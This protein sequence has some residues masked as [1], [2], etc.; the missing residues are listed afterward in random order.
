MVYWTAGKKDHMT[1]GLTMKGKAAVLSILVLLLAL[2]LV[3]TSVAWA[4]EPQLY[5]RIEGT[6]KWIKPWPPQYPDPMIPCVRVELASIK[7]GGNVTEG[8]L[9]GGTFTF[10]EWVA[11]DWE[12]CP[13]NPVMVIRNGARMKIKPEGSGGKV[14]IEFNGYTD[15]V[16][17]W[18]DWKVVRATGRYKG[19]E[20][21]GDYNGIADLCYPEYV[22]GCEGFSVNFD[23]Y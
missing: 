19:L 22:P 15:G 18:G 10:T 3:F 16:K 4:S 8:D 6:T 12:G 17:V 2:L 23:L 13:D 7:A 14:F 1:R 5:C 9:A 21:E 11:L 20:A